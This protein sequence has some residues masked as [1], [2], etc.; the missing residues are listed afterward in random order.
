ME[1]VLRESEITFRALTESTVSAIF[2][3]QDERICYVNPAAEAISGY[4]RAELLQM[5]F[6]DIVHPDFR[7]VVRAYELARKPDYPG[8]SSL[9]AP[10]S[11]SQYEVKFVT[12]TGE[13]RWAEVTGVSVEFAGR[14]ATLGT[15][16]DITKRKRVEAALRASEEKFSKAFR[17]SPDSI[18]ISTL[19]DGRIVEVNQGALQISGYSREEMIGR[20]S[21]ELNFWINPADR[22]KMQQML[23]QQGAVRNLEFDFRMK[24]GEVRVVLLSAEVIDFG[25]EPCLLSVIRDITDRRQTEEALVRAR[26]AEA[27][28]Q[29]LEKE[30]MERRRVEAA[31]RVT[32]E[33]FSK[34]FRSSPDSITITTLKEG[35]I[36]EVNDSCLHLNGY[37]REELIGHTVPELNFYADPADRIKMQQMLQ[38]QGA[39]RNL[40]S[41]FRIKSGEIRVVLLSAEIIN[42]GGESCLLA[43]VRDITERKRA[44][45]QLFRNAFYDTL[46]GLP[47]R[48]LFMDR[49]GQSLKRARPRV[50]P[51]VSPSNQQHNSDTATRSEDT[52]GDRFAVLFLD[53]DRFK[54]VNDSLGHLMGDQLLVAIAARLEQCLRPRDTAA[55]LGG[56]E[57]TI[58]IENV[59]D[60]SDAVHVAERIQQ[61][62]K[63]P[64]NLSGHEVFTSAS[65]GITLSWQYSSLPLSLKAGLPTYESQPEDLLRDADIAMYQAK[66]L[67]KA[68]HQV[69]DTSMRVQAVSLLQTESDLRRAIERQEFQVHYQPIVLLETS[70]LTGFEALVRW[71]HPDRGSVSPAE[72]IP[73]AEETGLIVPIGRWVLCEACRQ[74]RAWQLAYPRFREGD[75]AEPLTISVNLSGKQFLQP[76]LLLQISQVLQETGLAA[77][78]LKL[79]IT[80][81]VIIEQTES[82]TTILSQLKALGIH[83]YI[84][85]FGTGYSSLS[86]LHRFPIDRLKIDRSFVS[87][88]EVD[89][90]N[91][92]IVRT[93]VTLAHN[94]GIDVTAEGVET[95]EQLAQLQALGCEYGQGYFFSK[96][97]ESRLAEALIAKQ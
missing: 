14:P 37:S 75:L 6:W 32:E 92:E 42:F 59:K 58:L 50:G 65:I 74:V 30:I 29:A 11:P 77:D 43:V 72:F 96:P 85:D 68:R 56:D 21:L 90:E 80:E 53:L 5:S 69:F 54:V 41:K 36:V 60:V 24:S 3:R 2:I 23:Q 33:K 25:G 34:A 79:E 22:T 39:V 62:L 13:E 47:N 89:S 4:S 40:E 45:E 87:Q 82:T 83:L 88:M 93:I 57:F 18:T 44:E 9:L 94:L 16:F 71:Q 52:S 61:E 73:V 97:V 76:D 70:E 7:E 55:R 48:A 26:V 15:A 31:L 49:L 27:A 84:D 38:Q 64:F 81:S 8:V 12:K 20:T 46:T 35:R 66:A 19:Q 67:G 91:L 17:A 78:S 1:E 95:A 10:T 51:K 86:R 63:L 28:K